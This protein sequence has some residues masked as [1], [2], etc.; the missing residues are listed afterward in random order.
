M[1]RS[2]HRG[3]STLELIL[4]ISVI[5]LAAFFIFGSTQVVQKELR[6]YRFEGK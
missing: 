1:A 5:L 3:Q 4:V 6:Q 2:S